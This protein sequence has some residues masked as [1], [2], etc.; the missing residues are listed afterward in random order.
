MYNVCT[1]DQFHI[2]KFVQKYFAPSCF[3]LDPLARN[4][5]RLIDYRGDSICF[6]YD[7]NLDQVLEIPQPRLIPAAEARSFLKQAVPPLKIPTEKCLS[8]ITN[9]W[10][11]TP[12]P[13][14]LQQTLGFSDELYLYFLTRPVP[15]FLWVKSVVKK[16]LITP[17]EKCG[18]DLWYFDGGFLKYVY[19]CIGNKGIKMCTYDRWEIR[20]F[21]EAP[22][23]PHLEF[24]LM[25]PAFGDCPPFNP[26]DILQGR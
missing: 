14:T 17:E 6:M 24:C 23:S 7:K 11:S 15:D 5:A 1:I 20:L 19:G 2:L 3:V 10:S 25:N 22:D 18:I 4:I 21:H 16:E 26:L 9:W 13:L 12:T 8:Y